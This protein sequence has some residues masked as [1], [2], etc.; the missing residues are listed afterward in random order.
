[1]SF[2]E[3]IV[4]V[5]DTHSAHATAPASCFSWLERESVHASHGGVP[6]R[7]ESQ[8]ATELCGEL[9]EFMGMLGEEE[10]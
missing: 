8:P 7:H 1:M 3:R 9:A 10:D 6:D 4:V 5:T 2:P